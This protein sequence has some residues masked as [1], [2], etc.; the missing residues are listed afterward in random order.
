[1]VIQSQWHHTLEKAFSYLQEWGWWTF[2]VSLLTGKLPFVFDIAAADRIGKA[3]AAL[4]IIIEFWREQTAN[5][6]I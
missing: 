3:P 5:F 4:F 2:Y 6:S 1:M